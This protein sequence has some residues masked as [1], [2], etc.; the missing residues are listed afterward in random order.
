MKP[1]T[2][3]CAAEAKFDSTKGAVEVWVIDSIERPTP[4]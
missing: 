3:D 4:D 1:S 2:T